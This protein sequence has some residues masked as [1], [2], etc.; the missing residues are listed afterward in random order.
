MI[1]MLKQWLAYMVLFIIVIIGM[2]PGIA[3]GE[4]IALANLPGCDE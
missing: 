1:H 2:A 4:D 3:R